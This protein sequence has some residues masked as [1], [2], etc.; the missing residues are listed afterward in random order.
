MLDSVTPPV[1]VFDAVPGWRVVLCI[2]SHLKDQNDP[3]VRAGV[4]KRWYRVAVLP[5]KQWGL[6]CPPNLDRSPNKVKHGVDFVAAM[7]G[8]MFNPSTYTGVLPLDPTKNK[9]T[10]VVLEH[11]R[12]VYPPSVGDMHAVM[13]LVRKELEEDLERERRKASTLPGLS[14]CRR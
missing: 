5:I 14:T 6:P 11:L 4:D 9:P 12:G 3:D 13:I 2:P 7:F 8:S 1:V 10:F